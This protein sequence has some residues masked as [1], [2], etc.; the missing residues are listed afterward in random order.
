M[1]AEV[2]RLVTELTAKDPAARPASA[3]EVAARA[4]QLR[5]HPEDEVTADTSWLP[6][7]PATLMDMSAPGPSRGRWPGRAPAA[8]PPPWRRNSRLSWRMVTA[9]AALAL[10]GVLALVAALSGGPPPP[11]PAA[12]SAT[13]SPSARPGTVQVSADS[14]IGQPVELARQR[15]QQLGLT[16][17]VR[18][19]PSD[20]QA[21]T[22]LSVQPS[23]QV[24]AGSVIAITAAAPPH[25]D[26]HGY[27]N[28]HGNG[29]GGD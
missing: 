2:A 14:L 15:L 21:G 13:R 28:G 20:Q 9:V 6:V 4:S 17:E 5:D 8:R 16:V 23:G 22:V 27:G 24:P 19:H 1:P 10:V 3:D 12:G 25:H 18:W 26:R 29:D 7:F 11:G